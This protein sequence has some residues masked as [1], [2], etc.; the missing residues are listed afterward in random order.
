MFGDSTSTSTGA[1]GSFASF[2][3]EPI[4]RSS[5]AQL[6]PAIAPYEVLELAKGLARVIWPERQV[7]AFPA[8][9]P[10]VAAIARAAKARGVPV[11]FRVVRTG[12]RQHIEPVPPEP[13][14]DGEWP[15]DDAVVVGTELNRIIDP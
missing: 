11:R 2:R 10:L 13:P 5:T 12:D 3:T 7:G 14:A 6:N 8:L 4:R 9:V 1:F 15:V